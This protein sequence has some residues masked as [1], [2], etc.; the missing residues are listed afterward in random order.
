VRD[1]LV[2]TSGLDNEPLVWATAYSGIHDD[3][4]LAT[5]VAASVPD[6]SSPRGHFNYGNVGY[7]IT[8]VWTS[9]ALRRPW[10]QQL[11]RAVFQPLRMRHSSAYASRAGAVARPYSLASSTPD[12]PLYLQKADQ[13]M[14]AAGGVIATAPD[15]ARLLIAELDAGRVDGRQVFPAAVIARSQ[16]DQASLDARYL[17]FARTGYA[18]GWYSGEYKQRR[19]LHHFGGFAG[20][21]AHLSFMPDAGIGLVVLNNEDTLS[22][23]L[24]SLIA[25]HVYGRLLGDEAT[26]TRVAARFAELDADIATLRASLPAR[27]AALEAR[28]WQLQRPR[29]AY[30]G[31]YR[32]A[33]LGEVAVTVGADGGMHLA[34]GRVASR[35]TAVE[36]PDQVRVEFAPNS[37]QV[38]QFASGDSGVASLAFAGMRFD[39]VD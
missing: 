36:A 10:Q 39:R 18:W 30:A 33:L 37:G 27:R 3:A 28:R 16:Q 7:N 5:L 24:T 11:R 32:H 4:S 1:L 2:H 34:W 35:A 38:V 9:R 21:H 23:R 12:V 20:T 13:T 14:H 25:D 26:D 22:P 17:D 19:L 29:G 8:S 31:R 6:A 15:L